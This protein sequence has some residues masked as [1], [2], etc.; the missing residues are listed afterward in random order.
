M[1]RRSMLAL[2]ASGMLGGCGGG[3]ASLAAQGGLQNT[4]PKPDAA[5]APEAAPV[6]A[7]AQ[8]PNI[9]LWGDSMTGLYFPSMQQAFPDRHIYGGGISGETSM[10]IAAR[11]TAD[12]EHKTWISVF[13]YGHNNWTKDPVKADIAASVAALAPGNRAFIVMSMVNW[14]DSGERG[15]QEHA[16]IMRVNGE[17]AAAYP[18]NYLDIHRYLV[19]LYN[20]NSWQDVQD[21]QN[22][23][24]PSSLRFDKI[25]LNPAGCDAVAG[26][27]KEFITAKG[28]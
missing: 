4:E 24:P 18:D 9:A 10:Q 21:F 26:K 28:W 3:G 1:D 19:G 14:A 20:P 8:S 11:Q 5:P 27:L 17:L 15:T 13:W 6:P 23:L 7:Q 16:T 25:H 22:D 12:T 2:L